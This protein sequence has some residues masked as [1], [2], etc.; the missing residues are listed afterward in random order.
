MHDR[1]LIKKNDELFYCFEIAIL[2]RKDIEI[3]RQERTFDN[4]KTWVIIQEF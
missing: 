3:V 1:F 4:G 2:I